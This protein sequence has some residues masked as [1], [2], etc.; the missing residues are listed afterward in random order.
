MI[1]ANIILSLTEC[2]ILRTL[3]TQYIIQNVVYSFNHIYKPW[4]KNEH[5]HQ[6][7]S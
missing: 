4:A 6:R 2:E 1:A 3:T 7:V 5:A